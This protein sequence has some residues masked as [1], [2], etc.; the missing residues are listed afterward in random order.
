MN[1]INEIKIAFV[2]N[3]N[4]GK[5]TLFN[6]LT[7]SRQHVGNWPG[8]TIEH[9]EGVIVTDDMIYRIIDLPGLYSLSSYTYEEKVTRDFLINENIDVIVNIV[10]SS[11]LERNLYLTTQLIGI[12]IPV[13]MVYNMSDVVENSKIKVNYQ[14]I[15]ELINVEYITTMGAKSTNIRSILDKCKNISKNKSKHIP[16]YIT[17]SNE[18]ETELNRIE[19]EISVKNPFKYENNNSLFVSRENKNPLRLRWLVVK[20]LEEDE[21][22]TKIFKENINHS[23]AAV[24][25]ILIAKKHMENIYGQ[26]IRDII[27]DDRYGFV[28]GL[29][30]KWVNYSEVSDKPTITDKIDNVLLNKYSGIPLFLIIMYLMFT[31][32]FT[33][34]DFISGYI[35]ALVGQMSALANATITNNFWQAL[36]VDGVITG[37]GAV[38]LF[39]PTIAIMFMMISLLEDSGYLSR[40]AFLSDRAM[41]SMGLHGKSF[42]S[43]LLGFGCNVPA[44]MAARTLESRADR[45]VTILINPLMS[46]SARLPVYVLFTSVFFAVQYRSLIIFSIYAI[47]VVLAV[48]IGKIF[49][50]TMFDT[51]ESPFVMELPTYR[52]PTFKG[53][54]IHMWERTKEFIIRAGTIIVLVSVVVWILGAFPYGVEFGSAKSIIGKIGFFVEPIMKPIGL[55]WMAAVSFIFGIGAKEIIVSTLS[56]LTSHRSGSLEHVLLNT[57]TPLSAYVFMVFSLIYMPCSATIITMKKEMASWKYFF[58]GI[59][60]PLLLAWVIC[61]VIYQIGSLFI[62]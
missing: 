34:G 46:C 36:I 37:V 1:K 10:D 6:E 4:C 2:G 55:D 53:T 54:M 57:Y 3:P 47:G 58:I 38:F 33:L 44:V 42:I 8:V 59:I 19:K 7:G 21:S 5:T 43:L 48:I 50:K 40:A 41:H 27:T 11:I 12:G 23:T 16:R 32:T 17:Y 52:F 49:R 35:E 31:I 20:I 51:K 45:I 61:F 60:Y 13:L 18:L 39:I 29:I 28:G 56:I 22:V 25:K 62:H 24:E 30:N 15:S 26:N 9:K 14:K